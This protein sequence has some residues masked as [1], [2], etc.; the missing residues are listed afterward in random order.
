[1]IELQINANMGQLAEWNKLAAMFPREA[2]RAQGRAANTVKRKMIAAM[3]KGGGTKDVPRLAPKHAI[4]IALTGDRPIGGLLAEPNRIVA[5]RRGETQIVGWPNGLEK[6]G[7]RFQS[8][9]TRPM[10]DAER[11]YLYLRMAKKTGTRPAKISPIYMRPERPVVMP[12]GESVAKDY[13][14][15]ML[16]SLTKQVAAALD[17]AERK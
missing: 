14:R 12:L 4:T 13:P 2:R 8:G 11:R 3:K 5:F 17:R 7:S 16:S 10:E 9:A 1:M 6:A 15:W